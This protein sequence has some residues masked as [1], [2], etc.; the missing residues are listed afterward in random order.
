MCEDDKY[1][2][3]LKPH[4]GPIK[5]FGER[6]TGTRAVIQ[7]LY[8]HACAA[9]KFDTSTAY[10]PVFT[11]KKRWNKGFDKE[12]YKDAIEDIRRRNDGGV[13]TWKH[14]A[15]VI[16]GSYAAQNRAV[17]F[18]VRDPYSWM[19]SFFRKPYHARPPTPPQMEAFL[20]QPWAT[21]QRDNLAA[22]LPSPMALWSEKLR[23]YRAFLQ[24]APVPAG[25]LHFEDFVLDPVAALGAAMQGVGVAPEGLRGLARPTK[26]WGLSETERVAHYKTEAWKAEISPSAAALIAGLVD[27]DVAGYFGYEMR[28]PASFQTSIT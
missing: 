10:G 24:A 19:V 12:L 17:L 28:D 21:V 1:H 6:H 16:D 27:W 9:Q 22:M 23:A 5:V 13:G 15:P 4:P 8:E 11:R 18:L 14:A 7:M 2:L 20:Q 26:S 3:V 25:V